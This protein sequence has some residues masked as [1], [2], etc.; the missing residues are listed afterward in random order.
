MLIII[1]VRNN[2]NSYNKDYN[3]INEKTTNKNDLPNF[4]N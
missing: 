3:E 4:D 1:I 2:N